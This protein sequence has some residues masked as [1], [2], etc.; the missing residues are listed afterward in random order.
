MA[1]FFSLTLCFTVSRI[2]S[3]ICSVL[4]MCVPSG[5]RKLKRNSPASTVGKISTPS[6]PLAQKSVRP[7]TARYAGTTSQRRRTDAETRRSYFGVR[8]V[9]TALDSFGASESGADTPHSKD[10]S[11]H[12]ETTGTN[13]LDRTYEA[14]IEKPT[15]SD[16]G[17]NSSR[18]APCMKKLG[19]KTAR[20]QSIA[21]KRGIAVCALPIRTAQAIEFVWCICV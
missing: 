8:C 4:S 3:A 11:S 17:T 6:R 16:S 7:Q 9:S 1:T 14:I 2:S 21:S 13:V 10:R 15:D 19:T 12:V 20:M 5:A 18:A